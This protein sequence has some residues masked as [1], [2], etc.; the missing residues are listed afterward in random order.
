MDY[1]DLFGFPGERE[2]EIAAKP[3][4]V[5]KTGG[6]NKVSFAVTIPIEF[7][8]EMGLDTNRKVWVKFQLIKDDHN[9]N[10]KPYCIIE[11]LDDM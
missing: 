9:K 4:A 6:R 1:L 3:H 10:K 2:I 11:K 5:Y 7:A 8:K